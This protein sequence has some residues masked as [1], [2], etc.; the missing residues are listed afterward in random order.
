MQQPQLQPYSPPSGQIQPGQITYTTSSTPDGRITYHPFKAVP[1]SYQTANGVVSGIQWIPAEATSVLPAGAQPASADFAASWNRPGSGDKAMR[2]WQKDEEKRR[3]REEKEAAKRVAQWE[4]DRRD[5]DGDRHAR[6]KDAR[7]GRRLSNYST[8]SGPGS[9]P[10]PPYGTVHPSAVADLETRFEGVEIGRRDYDN[11]RENKHRRKSGVYADGYAAGVPGHPVS[12]GYTPGGFPAG[13]RAS[14]PYAPPGAFPPPSPSRPAAELGGYAGNP[15]YPG[16]PSSPGRVG[17]DAYQSSAT[18]YQ[19]AASPYQRAAS[20]YQRAASPYHAPP[21]PVPNAYHDRSRAPSPMPTPAGPYGAPRSRAPSP[22][23]GA[24][25]PYGAPR[26][27][28]PSPNPYGARS[29]APSP[30]PGASPAFPQPTVG[31]RAPPSPRPSPRVGGGGLP[32]Y[33]QEQ[34]LLTPPDG[35]SRPPNLAQSYTWFDIMKIQ[36]MDL[37]FK[38]MPRMPLVLVPHDVYHEDWIRF[39]QDLTLAW[40]GKLPTAD[41]ARHSQRRSAMT[42][43]LIDLWNTSFFQQRGVEVVLFKGRERRSGPAIGSIESRLPTFDDSDSISSSSSSSEDSD[44]SG[45]DKYGRAG[46][47]GPYARPTDP[48]S[49]EVRE[50]QRRT[51]EKKSEKKRREKEKKARRK[52][53]EREKA[54]ALYLTCVNQRDGALGVQF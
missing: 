35:F 32:S 1:A 3:R 18:P 4:K 2:E 8:V 23:P 20:P 5:R 26:S 24:V 45:D 17:G 25:G 54:Y 13:N 49:A 6:E 36:D 33:V 12:S 51:R 14:S 44:L 53:R 39:M 48:Y 15:V 41:P 11:Q 43:E 27:R 21:A 34:P 31:S 52:A 16:Y 50:A 19:R 22:I 10:Y 47:Y 29:R 46:P 7:S 37:F 9:G 38:T 28:A 42:A 40:A 30:I